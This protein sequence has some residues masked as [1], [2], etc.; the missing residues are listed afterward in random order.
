VQTKMGSP[1]ETNPN[2][3]QDIQLSLRSIVENSEKWLKQ[4]KRKQL[5]VRLV[6]S[7]LVAFL[8][9]FG[10]LI[11]GALIVIILANLT[12]APVNSSSASSTLSSNFN[13][14]VSNHP[15]VLVALALPAFIIAPI[16]WVVAY[17]LIKRRQDSSVKEL[18]SLVS[19][20]N[21]K[22]DEYDRQ[23]KRQSPPANSE[24]MLEDAFSLTDKI[25]DLVPEVARKRSLDPVLYGLISFILVSVIFGNLLAGLIAGVLVGLLLAYQANKSRKREI[26]KFEEQRRT[27]EDRKND[28]LATL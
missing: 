1:E 2:L 9:F 15:G 20:M 25:V 5:Q 10:T 17:L 12:P 11:I 21:R 26:A 7:F 4:L 13:T 27:Y 23:S 19:Q 14:Y 8:V 16:S 6:T 28:F 3:H 22:I 24:G 18:S